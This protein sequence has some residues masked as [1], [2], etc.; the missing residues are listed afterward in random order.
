MLPIFNSLHP[1]QQVRVE[2]QNADDLRVLN[3]GVE[4]DGE[5]LNYLWFELEE[6]EAGQSYHTFKAIQLRALTHIPVEVRDDPTVLGKMVTVLRRDYGPVIAQ[7]FSHAQHHECPFH[8][9]Q[10]IGRYLSRT[11]GRDPATRPPQVEQVRTAVVEVFRAHTKR[12]AAKRY[13]TLLAQQATYVEHAPALQ[14]V[15]EF[16]VQHWPTLVNALESE[17]VPKTNNAVEMV[18]RRFD[19]H[20]QNFCGFESLQSAQRYLAVFEKVYRFTPFSDDAQPGIRGKSPLQLAGYDVSCISMS[21][22]CRGYSLDWPITGEKKDVPN[23]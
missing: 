3:S 12:T 22:L 1:G 15:F 2:S 11:W 17:W 21:W 6:R 9:E 7:V 16:L 18:I 13:Q 8:A 4:F 23:S 20:Y 19:Q 5:H 14:W 10:E